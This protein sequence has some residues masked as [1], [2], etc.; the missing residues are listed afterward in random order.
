MIHIITHHYSTTAWFEIQKRHIL[1][2][3]DPEK[4]P[5]KLYL[6]KYNI[7][8]PEDFDLPDNWEIVDLDNLYPENGKNEHYLHMQWLYENCVKDKAEDDDIIMFLDSDAF[9]CD[10]RWLESISIGL[11]GNKYKNL[12]PEHQ[13]PSDY[14]PV[15][16]VVIHF[17]ENR[18]IAQPADYYP[19][20]DLCFF[21][22]L[23]KTWEDHNL[24]WY[25]DFS[26][27]MHQNPG[28]GMKDKIMQTDFGPVVAITRTNKF[29]AHNVMFGVYGDFL[30]HQHCGSRAIIGRPMKT[31]QSPEENTRQCFTGMDVFGR[32]KLGQ[33]FQQKF[34]E[35]CKDI[36]DTNTEIFD[37]IYNRLHNDHDCTFI[38]RYFLGLP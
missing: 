28:F 8:M 21:T 38:R 7:D 1:K 27:P 10:E 30:Y 2:Y 24:E 35:D 34:E 31:I 19:Y 25:I 36:V 32:I 13:L 14:E 26:N 3:S 11:Y 37:I 18:G 6:A 9:P 20:P 5:Y 29:N 33:W 12:I 16:A 23:K 4:T 22:T 17:L 15:K